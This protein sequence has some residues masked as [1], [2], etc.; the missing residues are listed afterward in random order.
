MGTVLG[1][2][3]AVGEA[4]GTNVGTVVGLRVGLNDGALVCTADPSHR[5]ENSW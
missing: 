1:R 2:G 4:V 5:I 3:V